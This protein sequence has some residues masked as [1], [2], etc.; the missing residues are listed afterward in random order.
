M[1]GYKMLCE[2]RFISLFAHFLQLYTHTQVDILIELLLQPLI[3]YYYINN[4]FITSNFA[5]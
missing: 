3:I 1:R 4:L 5:I 2:S